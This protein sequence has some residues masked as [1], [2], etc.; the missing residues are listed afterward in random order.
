[1]AWIALRAGVWVDVSIHLRPRY[2]DRIAARV[3]TQW[4]AGVFGCGEL[5]NCVALLAFGNARV[6]R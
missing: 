2:G 3:G 6:L 1:M 4:N 5:W